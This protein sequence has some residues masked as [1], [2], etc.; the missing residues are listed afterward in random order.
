MLPPSPDSDKEDGRGDQEPATGRFRHRPRRRPAENLGPLEIVESVDAAIEVEIAV[1][2]RYRGISVGRFT[3][4]ARPGVI[5]QPVDDA[6]PV[7]IGGRH[8][9]EECRGNRRQR[10]EE[11]FARDVDAVQIEAERRTVNQRA[12]ERD[13]AEVP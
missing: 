3:E 4:A 11:V 5:I 8:R 2:G 7:G 1:R 6:V 12:A 13:V 9:I 10:R